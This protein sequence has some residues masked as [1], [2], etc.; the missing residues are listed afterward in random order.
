MSST[1]PVAARVPEPRRP[2]ARRAALLDGLIEAAASEAAAVG[3]DATTVRSVARRAGVAPATAYTHFASKDH[4]LAEVM[5]RRM[6][7]LVARPPARGTT[8]AERLE[9]E[10]R[11]LAT[12]MAGEPA[13]AAAGAT[14]LLQPGAETSAI[15]TRIGAAAH[16]RLAAALGPAA[17]PDVLTALDILWSGALLWMGL[18]HLPP[19]RVPDTLATSGRLLMGGSR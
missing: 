16:A 5:G 9:G 1:T 4:L 13:L 12:F 7:Q 18:G 2:T 17:D 8:A 3:Y 10:L 15:R 6:D 11:L 19:E 14:A